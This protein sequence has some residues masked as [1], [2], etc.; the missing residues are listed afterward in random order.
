MQLVKC[1]CHLIHL[2]SSYAALKLPK[3]L[4]DL[5]IDVF[6]HFHRSSKRQAV[7]KEF[8]NFFNLEPLKLLGSGQTRWLSLQACVNRI[9][10]QFEALKHHFT[11][12]INEDPTH[13]NDR[14]HKSLNKN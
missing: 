2:V 7:Y 1:S 9:L 10:E 4:E 3:S 13:S 6:N 5:C 11:L 14:I 8:R 12:V